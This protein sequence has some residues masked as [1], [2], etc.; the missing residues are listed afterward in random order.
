[1]PKNTVIKHSATI[2]IS[3]VVSLMQRKAWNI[4]L[5]NAYDELLDKE[6][7]VISIQDLKQYLGFDSHNE[8]HLKGLLKALTSCQIEWNIL[9][10]DQLAEW[11][12]CS[13][14][15]GAT[16]KNGK[17]YYSYYKG[18]RE[19]LFNPKMYARINL[20]MQNKFE[21]KYAL[22]LYELFVDYYDVK[23]NCG[24]TPW[25]EIQTYRKLMGIQP[26]E[27]KLFSDMKKRLITAP[28]EEINNVP[29]IDLLIETV[30]RGQRPIEAVKFKIHSRSNSILPQLKEPDLFQDGMR[31]SLVAFG[32]LDKTAD[33]IVKEYDSSLIKQWMECIVRN[34][35]K[36]DNPAGFLVKALTENYALP[37]KFVKDIELRQS[38]EKQEYERMLKL[39]RDKE[40][41]E[42]A[43]RDEEKFMTQ[44]SKSINPTEVIREAMKMF[45]LK[46]P[47]H[48]EYIQS[49]AVIPLLDYT[50]E[51]F[52]NTQ[53]GTV[54]WTLQEYVFQMLR[55]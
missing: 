27:Y 49:Q 29:G 38:R 35:V 25:I 12:V 28:I 24:E 43:H 7:H 9:D 10:K 48:F 41:Q 18:L 37:P 8:Q 17:V 45:R 31:E 11:T 6:E 16:I 55:F 30:Y 5:A 50:Y 23:R 53:D 32:L 54:K 51:L 33:K 3:N 20:S 15:A 42:I 44:L 21:S 34:Y 22:A 39:Q 26:N 46:E 4:L 1:M 19:K 52:L 2:Q 36:A 47:Q 14:L 13:F 40:E